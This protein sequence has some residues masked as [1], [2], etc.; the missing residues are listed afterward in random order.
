M[1]LITQLQMIQNAA[2]KI[3]MG[4]YKYD[5]VE[6]DLIDLHW[7]SIRKRIIF[8]IALIV[9]KAV[10]GCT[11]LYI[12]ELFQYVSH[13]DSFRLDVPAV[14]TR[15]GSRA[16]SVIGPKVYNSLPINIR[17]AETVEIFKMNLKTYL[18]R[19]NEFEIVFE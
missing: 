9:H 6:N 4:K 12:Q 2:S 18:F 16:L 14:R 19:K 10:K 5:H 11:P 17:D 7:L 13:G 8:K 15:Y 3:I 1:A